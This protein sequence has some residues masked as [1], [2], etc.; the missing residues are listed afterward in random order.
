MTDLS[1][2]NIIHVNKGDV[3]YIQFRKLLEYKD[4]ISHCYSLKGNDNNY[5]ENNKNCYEKIYKELGLNFEKFKRIEHQIHSDKVE[6]VDDLDKTYTEVDGLLTNL[7]GTSLFLRFADCTPVLLYD[8]VKNVIGNIHSG[9]RGTVQKI[10]QKGV[11]KMIE[12]YNSNKEDII[13]CIGP[14]IGRCHFEVSE[15]VKDIFKN[16][17]SYLLNENVF[18]FLGNIKD[19]EQKYYIDTN[20]VIRKMLEEIGIRPEN[21]VESN[22]CTVCNSD[23]MHSYRAEK[24]NSGRNTAII[25]FVEK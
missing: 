18:I 14:A 5:K 2:E 1:N 15:D 24:E 4:K 3:Q 21:I 22:V 17:F 19:G 20:I 6:I 13:C 12:K 8:P 10:P 25:G 23:L 7:D 11:L 9:W 16:T